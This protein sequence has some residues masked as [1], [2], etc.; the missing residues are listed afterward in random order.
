MSKRNVPRHEAAARPDA[1]A[2]RIERRGGITIT[3][4]PWVIVQRVPGIERSGGVPANIWVDPAVFVPRQPGS[5]LAEF[6]ALRQPRPA[7]VC[8]PKQGGV[9]AET[10]GENHDG[11]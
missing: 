3:T 11:R 4:P 1:L 6:D 7:A 10:D 9:C 2:S 5:F 8:E